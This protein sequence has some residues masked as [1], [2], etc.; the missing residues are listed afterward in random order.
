MN[1]GLSGIFRKMFA[2]ALFA[3]IW[4]QLRAGLLSVRSQAGLDFWKAT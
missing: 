4:G 2:V 3:V 1:P